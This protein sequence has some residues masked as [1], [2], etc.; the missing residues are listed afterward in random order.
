ML[1]VVIVIKELGLQADKDNRLQA[2]FNLKEF[3]LMAA[4]VLITHILVCNQLARHQLA[5]LV[6]TTVS[7]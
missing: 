5:E 2:F 3:T 1:S 4:P 6:A 7:V